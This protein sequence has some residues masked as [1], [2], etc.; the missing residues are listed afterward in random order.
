M[1]PRFFLPCFHASCTSRLGQKEGKNS[2]HNL[3]YG[4]RTRLI[5]GM[6]GLTNSWENNIFHSSIYTKPANSA[7]LPLLFSARALDVRRLAYKCFSR[8]LIGAFEC[9][10]YKSSH[11]CTLQCNWQFKMAS[12]FPENFPKQLQFLKI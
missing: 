8:A 6:Y 5:R 10:H 4:P 9:T 3:P 11:E 2:V 1:D 12:R 7:F